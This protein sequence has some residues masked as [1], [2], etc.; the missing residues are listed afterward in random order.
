MRR[1]HFPRNGNRHFGREE[2]GN[3]DGERESDSLPN[4]SSSGSNPFQNGVW[5]GGINQAQTRNVGIEGMQLISPVSA[6]PARL[7][8]SYS[9]ATFR[10]KPRLKL[11]VQGRFGLPGKTSRGLSRVGCKCGLP[12]N[13][14]LIESDPGGWL[15]RWFGLIKRRTHSRGPVPE[16]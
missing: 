5:H 8:Q 3:L 2:A 1:V 10:G 11:S 6:M 12:L 13:N 4:S 7:R 9:Q 14:P 16:S 15:G